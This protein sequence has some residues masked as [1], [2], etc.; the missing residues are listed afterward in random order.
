MDPH[1]TRFGRHGRRLSFRLVRRTGTPERICAVLAVALLIALSVC[2]L[3][4]QSNHHHLL[5]QH[6]HLHHGVALPPTPPSPAA[7]ARTSIGR[8]TTSP[9]SAK[10]SHAAS[11]PAACRKVPHYALGGSTPVQVC[12]PSIG[13]D[14]SVMQL[15]LNSDRTVQVPPLSRVQ[16][17]GWYKYS[18]APG[19]TGPI[20]ILG[21]VDS[22]QYGAGV[23]FRLGQLATGD[24][25]LIT[26]SDGGVATY[27]ITHVTEV[28]KKRFPSQAVYGPTTSKAIRLVTCGGRFDATTGNYLDNIIAWGALQS[29]HAA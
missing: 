20:V 4:R 24:R 15:G 12:L 23:F 14:A 26:R 17:A 1:P 11:R 10:R 6:H 9:P 13:V 29:L 27:L 25:V 18:A 21:H 3:V 16:D 8:S 22:A 28:P 2:G 19:A 7:S 5:L